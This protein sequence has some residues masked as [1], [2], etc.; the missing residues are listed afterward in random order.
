MPAGSNPQPSNKVPYIVAIVLL[1][2]AV[3]VLGFVSFSRGKTNKVQSE[4]LTEVKQLKDEL[5]TQYYEA[6]TELEEL[7]GSN[8]Q[9]NALIDQQKTE[10]TAQKEKIDR[11]LRDGRNLAEARKEIQGLKAQVEQYLAEINQLREENKELM[12]ENSQ[13]SIVKDSLSSNLELAQMRNQEL[14]T[15]RAALV[16]EKENLEQDRAVLSEK[17]S[18]ASVI[19]VENIEVTGLKMRSSGKAVKRRNASNVDQLQICFSTTVNQVTEPRLEEFVVRI[20]DPLGETLAIDELGSGIFTSN[21]T[22]EQIRYTKIKEYDYNRDASALC[23]NW[24]PNIE[25]LEGNYDIEIYNK[26]YLAGSG[27]FTLK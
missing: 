4:E 20:I 13:L 26:G 16:S 17:V 24:Q 19:K 7:Q 10:L 27:S 21:A 5:E 3:A 25:F 6:M 23:M 14:N 2:L 12:A 9:L 11:L 22:G 1:S 18:I 15:A 8:E